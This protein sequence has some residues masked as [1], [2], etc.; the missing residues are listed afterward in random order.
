MLQIG[1]HAA[2]LAPK[3]HFLDE[4]CKFLEIL[5]FQFVECLHL[6][7]ILLLCLYY[8][9]VTSAS[10]LCLFLGTTAYLTMS[11]VLTFQNQWCHGLSRNKLALFSFFAAIKS[12]LTSDE[13]PLPR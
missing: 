13:C 1:L 5:L 8:V 3:V 12:Q 10:A 9:D 2:L 11:I 7:L 4:V 6:S